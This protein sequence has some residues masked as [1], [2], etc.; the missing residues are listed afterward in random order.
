LH[1]VGANKPPER[2]GEEKM[3]NPWTKENLKEI[4]Y[5]DKDGKE[6]VGH[7]ASCDE[8]AID[9]SKKTLLQFKYLPQP[10]MGDPEQ[11]EIFLL[12]GNPNAPDGSGGSSHE[13]FNEYNGE[14]IRK[15]LKGEKI[16]YPLYALKFKGYSIYN[17]WYPRLEELIQIRGI[18]TVSKKLFD[19]EFFPYFSDKKEDI[20][21]SIPILKPKKNCE[22]QYLESQ[23]YT[24]DLIKEAIDKE[25]MIV[26]MRF[27]DEWREAVKKLK[28]YSKKIFKDK[29]GKE[30]IRVSVLNSYLNP[31]VS[32]EQMTP[33]P[34]HPER[35]LSEGN[36]ER[37]LK[38]LKGETL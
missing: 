11:A 18:E 10:Y 22:T 27:E 34:N 16:D 38:I 8:G 24:F 35:K 2:A 19:A 20:Y 26:I 5:I 4:K 36:F 28:D 32:K 6:T 1:R 31:H 7:I 21:E 37:I 13:L 9:L 29:E 25:K 17:W 12:N 23:K 15:N 30:Y 33:R 3:E 14:Y